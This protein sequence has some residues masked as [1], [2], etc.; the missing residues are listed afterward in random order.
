MWSKTIIGPL[1]ILCMLDRK[2]S[3]CTLMTNE[4]E[5]F[6]VYIIIIGEC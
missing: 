2:S 6:L 1:D 3:F 5:V 4:S